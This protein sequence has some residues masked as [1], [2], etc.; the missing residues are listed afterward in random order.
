MMRTTNATLSILLA[1]LVWQGD[2]FSVVQQPTTASKSALFVATDGENS[3]KASIDRRSLFQV[4]ATAS[5]ATLAMP[6]PNRYGI[7]NALDAP[8]KVV[9]AGATGQTGRRILER[10]AAN[11]SSGLSVVGGVR[12]VEKAT[13]ALQKESTVIRGAMVQKVGSVDTSAVELKHLDVVKDSVDELAATLA[14]ADSLVIAT[15]FIP[16]M[17]FVLLRRDIFSVYLYAMCL[18]VATLKV[19]YTRLMNLNIIIIL[20]PLSL[21][22]CF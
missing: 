13:E 12:N 16:G 3:I 18:L 20:P 11:T 10:L 15:G 14:G 8:K 5:L 19:F 7:A 9:V 17:F 22:F 1:L 2:S 21:P 4:A 6:L